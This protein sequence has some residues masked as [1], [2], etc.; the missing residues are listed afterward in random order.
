MPTNVRNPL[1][2]ATQTLPNLLGSE[3]PTGKPGTAILMLLD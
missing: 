1:M 3:D 2:H